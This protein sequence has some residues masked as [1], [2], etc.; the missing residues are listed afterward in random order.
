MSINQIYPTGVNHP[1]RDVEVVWFGPRLLDSNEERQ[2][3]A[4]GNVA[5]NMPAHWLELL[6]TEKGFN[7]YW[8]ENF[9]WPQNTAVRLILFGQPSALVENF[10]GFFSLARFSP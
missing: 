1:A 7:C 3:P 5:F 2:G 6:V 10:T 8:L 4:Y 9:V